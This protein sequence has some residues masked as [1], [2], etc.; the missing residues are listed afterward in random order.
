MLTSRLNPSAS[1]SYSVRLFC[2]SSEYFRPP[3]ERVTS[4]NSTITNRSIPVEYP[5]VPDIRVDD[6]SIPFKE[7]GLRGKAGSA[8]PFD[9]NRTSRGLTLVPNRLGS[10][11]FGHTGATTGKKK[12]M[13]K[14]GDLDDLAHLLEILLPDCSRRVDFERSFAKKAD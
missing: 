4:Y 3:I 12:E 10:V 6:L 14:V 2:C 1:P 9:I 13:I 5:A 8:P 11:T 7:R